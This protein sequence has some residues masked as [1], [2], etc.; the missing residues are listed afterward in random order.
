MCKKDKKILESVEEK[1]ILS[2]WSEKERQEVA[3]PPVGTEGSG[4]QGVRRKNLQIQM[5]T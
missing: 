4:R 1:M 2:G 3:L 5:K